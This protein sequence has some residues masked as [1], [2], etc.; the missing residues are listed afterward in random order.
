MRSWEIQ[1]VIGTHV[2]VEDFLGKIWVIPL[3]AVED[4]EFSYFLLPTDKIMFRSSPSYN[5]SNLE[6]C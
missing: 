2:T 4:V 6:Y 5:V 1:E 3:Q